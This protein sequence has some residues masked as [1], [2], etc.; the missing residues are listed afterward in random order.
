M[1][2]TED[3]LRELLERA[4][5]HVRAINTALAAESLTYEELHE[6][7]RQMPLYQRAARL[8]KGAASV[9]TIDDLG[10]WESDFPEGGDDA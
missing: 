3:E 2:A 10:G 5:R 6:L 7:D 1:A 9:S 8:A 4:I